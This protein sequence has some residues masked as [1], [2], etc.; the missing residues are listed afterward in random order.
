MRPWIGVI[1]GAEMTAASLFAPGAE[2]YHHRGVELS[3]GA[4]T[5]P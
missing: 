2:L 1:H 5:L 3:R 4:T